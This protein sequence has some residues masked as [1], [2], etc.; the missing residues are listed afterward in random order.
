MY[1][2][3]QHSS[4]MNQHYNSQQEQQE[5]YN[6]RRHQQPPLKFLTCVFCKMEKSVKEF[7]EMQVAK[8]TYN[9][10]APSLSSSNSKYI[11]CLNCTDIQQKTLK[12]FK[13]LRTKQ[14]NGFSKYQKK[15]GDK[16]RCHECMKK[17]N[18]EDVNDSEPSYSSDEEWDDYL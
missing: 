3:I 5:D 11:S 7:S 18:E 17:R 16:A 13:C 12:C 2:R 10:Y 9:L 6:N 4:I 15:Q 1:K 14:L 8:A